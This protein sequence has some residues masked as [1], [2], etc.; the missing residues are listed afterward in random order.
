MRYA[1]ALVLLLAS[2]PAIASAG[3]ECETTDSSEVTIGGGMARAIAAP[4]ERATLVIGNLMLSTETDPPTLA[5]G[6]SW[7]DRERLWVDLVDP[8]LERFEAQLR[9]SIDAEG[10]AR[11]ALILDG[12]DYPISCLFE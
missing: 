4:L 11:G 9:V 6:Q 10:D 7:L 12:R 1:L 2:S 3:F 8:Q 5:I